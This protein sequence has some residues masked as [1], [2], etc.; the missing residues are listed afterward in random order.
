MAAQVY[1]ICKSIV[2]DQTSNSNASLRSRAS[3]LGRQPYDIVSFCS[4]AH[5]FAIK[6]C[7]K[8]HSR[9]KAHGFEP[10]PHC[11]ASSCRK[12]HGFGRKPCDNACFCFTQ[13]R[14]ER[15]PC[16]PNTNHAPQSLHGWNVTSGHYGFLNG[17]SQPK[18]WDS[19]LHSSGEYSSLGLGD[20]QNFL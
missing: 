6:P 2:S 11:T 3:G 1:F 12:A 10:K 5:S 15:K 17:P 4:K 8:A 16:W 7:S 19:I 18:P 13:H 9:C 14:F 20:F